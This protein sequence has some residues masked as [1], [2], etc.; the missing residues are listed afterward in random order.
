MHG[1]FK[2]GFG[3]RLVMPV[4]R[5]FTWQGTNPEGRGIP[6]AVEVPFS[7]A[8]AWQGRDEQLEAATQVLK[9]GG[10]AAHPAI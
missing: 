1:A 6:P 4:A 10:V 9:M 7:A 8:A 3:Y 2:V 5:Y